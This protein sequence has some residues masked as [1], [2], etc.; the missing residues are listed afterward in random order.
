MTA[1]D[2]G[3]TRAPAGGTAVR[4]SSNG[5]SSPIGGA[6][7][8]GGSARGDSTAAGG[9]AVANTSSK[10][11]TAEGG[12]GGTATRATGGSS[13]ATTA[14]A[15]GGA[16]TTLRG[17][18]GRPRVTAASGTTLVKIDPAVRH[19]SFEGWGTS[20]CW[21]AHQIGAW[22][23]AKRNQLLDLVVNPVT[24]LGYSIFRYNIG[25]GDAPS[26]DHMG[27]NREMPGFQ[28]SSGVWD[29]N[30]DARQTAVLR[31]LV[32]TG[33]N[34]IIE[35]FSNSPPYWMTKS[36]CASGST[37]GSNN[38]KDDAYG[39]FAEYLTE[40][41]KHYR[42]ELGITFRTLEPMNEPNANWWKANGGQEGC[43][44]GASSQQQLIKAV[45]AELIAKGLTET[46]ISA[47]DENSMDDA[48]S[49]MSGYDATTLGHVA[50]MNVHSY[51]GT[52]RTQVRELAASK[53]KRLWQSE[54]GPLGTELASNLDAAIFM[55]G[56]IIM[57]LRELKP[58]AWLEW[59]VV[60]SSLP[61]T[62]FSVNDSTETW[63]PLKRF[64]AQAGFSRFIRPGAHFIDIDNANMVAA[65][66]SDGSSLTVVVRNGDT[67]VSKDYV[68]DLTALPAVGSSVV[69]HRTSSSEDLVQLS[70]ITLKDYSVS[71]NAAPY[72]VTTYVF[73]LPK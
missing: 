69:V 50:Q 13:P 55:A 44:F 31:R 35:A 30:A 61:W 17:I 57:D 71:V 72:S 39:P 62:S 23:A 6:S 14:G 73:S 48:F 10:G 34:V 46:Q 49:I 12:G 65:L 40:V 3:S 20:L 8:A 43:H 4:G 21:W 33:E 24:G 41:T 27:K 68:F 60:D 70:P 47:S 9:A 66:S 18:G 16:T 45:A 58:E 32:E 37:D 51:A 63:T 29:W 2:S 59:Q 1:S 42:D 26:H 36:G 22:S 53:G 25:G 28:S 5:T 7:G 15:V 56:R 67:T 52:R 54:S 38:L 19:Q 11:R 64:Y